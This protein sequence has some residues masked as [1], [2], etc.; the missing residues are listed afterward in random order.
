MEREL[1]EKIRDALGIINESK[2]IAGWHLNGDIEPW[3]LTDFPGLLDEINKALAEPATYI[4]VG[5]LEVMS[6]EDERFYIEPKPSVHKQFDEFL[7][8]DDT[9]YICTK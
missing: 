5:T 7:A 6:Y 9:V 4:P 1:L 2:G 3:G 8:Y